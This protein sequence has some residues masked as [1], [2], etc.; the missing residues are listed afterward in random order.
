MKDWI[1][2][3]KDKKHIAKEKTR[4]RE[5]R[6]SL[7]WKNEI[8]KGVCHYCCKNFPPDELTM[9]HIVPI[10]RG[11]KSSKRNVVA[12]CKE[13]NY[14]KKYLTPADIILENIKNKS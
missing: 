9:D 1:D 5:L 14:K 10:S 13:C 12:C 4:A 6:K 3:N 7:W 11:G 2:I 8:A